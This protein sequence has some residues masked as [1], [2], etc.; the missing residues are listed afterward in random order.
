MILFAY[1][2]NKKSVTTLNLTIVGE[3]IEKLMG[4]SYHSLY[5]TDPHYRLTPS[6]VTSKSRK[7]SYPLTLGNGKLSARK[8]G[9]PK[10]TLKKKPGLLLN[11]DLAISSC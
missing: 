2:Q 10:Q 3:V 1:F 9:F 11:F 4:D 6:D 8:R 5:L 7:I